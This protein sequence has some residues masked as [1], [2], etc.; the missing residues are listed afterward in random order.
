MEQLLRLTRRVAQ[1]LR[2][3]QVEDLENAFRQ[4]LSEGVLSRE[5]LPAFVQRRLA[6]ERSAVIFLQVQEELL[7]R[8]DAETSAEKYRRYLNLFETIFPELLSGEDLSAAARVLDR[9]SAHRTAGGS[10]AERGD[11]A[12]AWIDHLAR[13]SLRTE[14]GERLQEADRVNRAALLELG[15]QL[16]DAG[17][18]LLFETLRECESAPCRQD[19]IQK[20]ETLKA[21]SLH[22]LREQLEK[23][24]L[25]GDYLCDLLGLLSRAGDPSSAALA[26][27]FLDHGDARIRTEALC[28]AAKLDPPACERWA[29]DALADRDARVAEAALKLLFDERCTA[30]PLFE[31]CQRILSHL[32]EADE[33]MARRI[34]SGLAGYDSGEARAKSVALLLA[35]LGYADTEESGWWSAVRRSV[36]GEPAHVPVKLAACQALGRMRATEGVNVLTHLGKERNPAL[37]HAAARALKRIAGE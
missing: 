31:F 36:A 7:G 33:E 12:D 11:V 16:G 9:V 23:S 20:L 18:A 10:F 15:L 6:I 14:F 8:F 22:H 2:R 21:R 3:E 34:C 24:D 35:V 26:L 4:L 25:P 37:K 30:L 27:R 29:L 28:A 17:V 1:Q 5:E 32:D 13:T 19:L